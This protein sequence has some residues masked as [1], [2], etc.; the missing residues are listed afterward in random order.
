VQTLQNDPVIAATVIST[1]FAI[2]IICPAGSNLRFFSIYRP[3]AC[4]NQRARFTADLVLFY[5]A[6]TLVFQYFNYSPA[7]WRLNN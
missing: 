3:T 7:G 1:F 5:A 4:T 2:P 6:R